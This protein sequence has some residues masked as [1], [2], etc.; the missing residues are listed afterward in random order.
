VNN[1][2]TLDTD[3]LPPYFKV[4]FIMNTVLSNAL[5]LGV[6][7]MWG[8]SVA[9]IPSGWNQA[10]GTN[11]TPNLLN[12]FLKGVATGEQPG[13]IGGSLT[14]NHSYTDVPLHSHNVL[15]DL[16]HHRHTMNV[17]GTTTTYSNGGSRMIYDSGSTTGT[18][19]SSTPGSPAHNHNVNPT[20]D[21]NPYTS[22]ENSLP[23]YVKLIYIQK[24]LSISNPSPEDGA[25]GI[26]YSP[27]LSV[28][29]ND[30]DGDDLNVS[31]YNASDHSLLDTDIILGGIGT[32]SISLSGLSSGTSYSWY[33]KSNDSSSIR[34]SDTWTFTT[35]HVPD[36]PMNP[37]PNDGA[38]G[39]SYSPTLSVDVFDD[40]EDDLNVSFYNASDNSIIDAD[41]ITGGN[42]TASVN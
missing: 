25:T 16:M 14:H 3:N 27:I 4:A 11:N 13:I 26:N 30:I 10:N 34:R 21:P 41:I 22:Y 39:I 17:I 38:I 33:V 42:G 9:N 1:A 29:V 32:A 18:S 20:G 12:K 15:S 28:D 19:D 24:R 23:P 7:S 6:I 8:D 2:T 40:D 35:N 37:T 5:P 36:D 31:F